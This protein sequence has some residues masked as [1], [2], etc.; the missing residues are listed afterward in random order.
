MGGGKA[1]WWRA[2]LGHGPC[3]RLALGSC[4]HRTPCQSLG[5]PSPCDPGGK[6]PPLS[7]PAPLGSPRQSPGRGARTWAVPAPSETPAGSP[8][9]RH[10]LGRAGSPHRSLGWRGDPPQSPRQIWA[11]PVSHQWQSGVLLAVTLSER[12][13]RPCWGSP[14][15]HPPA[16]G[17]PLLLSQ[18]S[19]RSP[20]R[21]PSPFGVPPLLTHLVPAPC[22]PSLGPHHPM[23]TR[24]LCPS[25]RLHE[26]CMER[27]QV[28]PSLLKII[29]FGS[30]VVSGAP[31]C[32]SLPA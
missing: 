21:P 13:P 20:H 9:P 24:G 28:L 5:S 22:L 29:K 15:S 23:D 4:H 27:A 12:G 17:S 32:P 7:L 26:T 19:V 2:G 1:R 25:A 3:Q 31:Y 8:L 11:P 18:A 14:I 30:V 6:G 10:H 16:V